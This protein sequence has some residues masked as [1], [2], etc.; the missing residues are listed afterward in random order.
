[1]MNFLQIVVDRVVEQCYMGA[2]DSM[3]MKGA[4][5]S[6]GI[7]EARTETI[8]GNLWLYEGDKFSQSLTRVNLLFGAK[9]WLQVFELTSWLFIG[10]IWLLHELHYWLRLI[11]SDL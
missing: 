10:L 11:I 2:V 1:M 8:R 6:F 4:G 3:I 9:I 7:F 5:V